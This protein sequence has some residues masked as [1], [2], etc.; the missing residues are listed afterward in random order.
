MKIRKHLKYIIFFCLT[1][2]LIDGI[3]LCFRYCSQKKQIIQSSSQRLNDISQSKTDQ[4]NSYIN[5]IKNEISD[6]VNSNE[7]KF[8]L[9]QPVVIDKNIAKVEVDQKAKIIAKEVENYIKIYPKRTFQ[10]FKDD[11]VFQK[12]TVQD[13][14]LSGYSTV[15]NYEEQISYF[16]KTKKF[17]GEKYQNIESLS[18]ELYQK[19]ANDIFISSDISGFYKLTGPD[20]K[21]QDK[22]LHLIHLK[23]KTVDNVSLAVITTALVGD[24]K[25]IKEVSNPANFFQNNS[26][27]NDFNNL[28][29]I[30]PDGT[31]IY[32][33]DPNKEIGINLNWP[34]NK[35][36]TLTKIFIQSQKDNKTIFSDAF[37]D[38]YGEIY[39]EFIVIS[40]VY[41]QNKLLG[42]VALV[43]DMNLIFEITKDPKNLGQTG[44]S[45]LVDQ[46][47]KLLISPLRHNL[48]DMFVQNI[49]T[50]NAN[51]CLTN[52]INSNNFLLNY[53]GD[54]TLATRQAI[55]EPSWCLLTEINANEI[56]N[57]SLQKEVIISIA[58]FLLFSFIGILMATKIN[59][60]LVKKNEPARQVSKFK[61][62]ISQ[63]S[64][65]NIIILSIIL[66]V[67]YFFIITPFFQGWQ[68]AAFYNDIPDLFATVILLILFFHGFKFKNISSQKLILFGSSMAIFDKL[69]QIILEEYNYKFG[70]IST[71]FWLPG[72]TIGFIGLFLIFYG[73][74]KEKKL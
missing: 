53:R 61:K 74:K 67:I 11:P 16:Q 9:K 5:E 72:T 2:I 52:K 15:E 57:I 31:I 30:N 70:L 37:I 50:D 47:S 49:D 18:P 25:V 73:F 29:L 32:S 43:K 45:Y 13:I 48:F 63:L 71:Y 14:G 59:I 21:A 51:D 44:E 56:L 66:T 19:L 46:M 58:I 65:K 41:D 39:P 6:L 27:Q 23:N 64:L 55:L 22:Y 1:A 28:F 42:Y 7:T 4:I 34:V 20:G 8:L 26:S 62:M 54:I 38:S 10:E 17:L 40:P 35:N 69:I 36:L 24:Y 3:F 60:K 12:I 33:Q 68:N